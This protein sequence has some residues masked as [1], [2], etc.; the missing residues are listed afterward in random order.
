MPSWRRADRWGSVAPRPSVP[1]SERLSSR[2]W[3]HRPA[4]RCA[5]PV[6]T[7]SAL[8]ESTDQNVDGTEAPRG[9]QHPCWRAL[10]SRRQV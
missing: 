1:P 3:A 6:G 5:Q 8:V 9:L 4:W 2:R 7:L 10:V